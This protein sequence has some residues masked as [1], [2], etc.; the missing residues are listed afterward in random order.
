MNKAEW[1]EIKNQFKDN[2]KKLSLQDSKL[3][4][5][6]SNL[7]LFLIAS[8]ISTLA[9]LIAA[10]VIKQNQ[11][12]DTY[13]GLFVIIFVITIAILFTWERRNLYSIVIH[14]WKSE[15]D[16]NTLSKPLIYKLEFLVFNLSLKRYWFSWFISFLLWGLIICCVFL[17]GYYLEVNHIHI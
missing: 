7:I 13:A 3:S 6:I 11:F 8:A 1:K 15:Y 4:S 17:F 2:Y 5:Y 14:I 9:A 16:I 12:I 10:I